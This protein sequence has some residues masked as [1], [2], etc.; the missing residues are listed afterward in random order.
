MSDYGDLPGAWMRRKLE[1][2]CTVPEVR[3]QY[4]DRPGEYMSIRKTYE[5]RCPCAECRRKTGRS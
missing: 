1:P 5:E 2:E 4:G 3:P